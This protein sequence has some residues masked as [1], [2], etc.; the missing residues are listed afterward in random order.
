[1]DRSKKNCYLHLLFP[2][3]F[4]WTHPRR[5]RWRE[6]SFLLHLLQQAVNP[7]LSLAFACRD[8]HT[9][10]KQLKGAP[11]QRINQVTQLRQALLS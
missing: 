1:M 2:G 8:W 9:I 6:E 5:S 3:A 7:L 11:R 10:S 4:L